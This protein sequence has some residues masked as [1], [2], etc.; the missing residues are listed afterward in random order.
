MN[1]YPT[2]VYTE[3]DP[4]LDHN[5][6]WTHKADCAMPCATQNEINEQDAN[7]LVNNGVRSGQ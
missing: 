3:A 4:G 7:N 5:P 2:A 1:V 6:F